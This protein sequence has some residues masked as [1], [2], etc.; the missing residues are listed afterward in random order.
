V[1]SDID[2]IVQRRAHRMPRSLSVLYPD[3]PIRVAR[4]AG[5]YLYDVEGREY[6]DCMNN[7]PH[8]G[9]SHPRVNAAITAQLE[10]VNTNSRF[11]Y[12]QL[13]DYGDALAALLPA[14]LEVCFF[15]NSG[16]EANEL[17]LRLVTNYTART[18]I[19]VL[20]GAYHGNTGSLVNLSPYK[21]NGRGGSGRPRHVQMA[22]TPDAYRGVHRGADTGSRYA[23][24]V[25]AAL[26]RGASEGNPCAA[27]LAE[28]MMGTA[29]QIVPPDGFL[30]QAY[31]HARAAGAVVIADEV[32]IGFGRVGSHLWGFEAL[33]AVPDIVTLGKPIGNGFPLGAV[34]TTRE[35]ADAFAN[36]MEYFNTFGGSPVSCAA[37]LAVLVVIED[38][39]LQ[40]HAHSVGQHLMTNL[41][42][43]GRHHDVIGDVRG[44]GLF[45]GVELVD[46]E[47]EPKPDAA[48]ARTLV[49][50][51]R[52]RRILVGTDG[53]DNN[54][55]KIKPPLPFSR[56]DAD[57]L[58]EALDEELRCV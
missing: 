58:A 33:G 47:D 20:D 38:E 19:C 56:D 17:A 53:P 1:T 26:D 11:L 22:P 32:Q 44:T 45:L 52:E 12:P 23:A 10:L 46:A 48:T 54:V 28:P 8:V 9:H 3:H 15:V 41:R 30:P 25:E 35:I 49:N 39:G 18:G 21:F 24:E 31:A 42:E 50:A 57:R 51:L 2:Q 13:V 34:V 40:A 14:P 4:G 6:L 5:Q 7:V 55:L 16:S 36:G 43:I 27:L 37:G 29:G